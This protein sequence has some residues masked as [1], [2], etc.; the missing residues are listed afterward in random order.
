MPIIHEILES[1]HGASY[2]S[3]LALQYGYWQ[4][5]MRPESKAKTA[6]ITPM[7]GKPRRPQSGPRLAR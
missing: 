5:A 4:V 2:F 6:V 3:T 7:Y 1:L